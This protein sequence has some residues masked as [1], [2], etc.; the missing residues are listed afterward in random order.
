[1]DPDDLTNQWDF[2]L[3]RNF[4][5]AFESPSPSPQN[6]EV[7][8]SLPSTPFDPRSSVPTSLGDF[9]R[10]FRYLDLPIDTPR[11]PRHNP[12]ESSS[13]STPSDRHSTGPSSAPEDVKQFNDFIEIV[14]EVR[15]KDDLAGT[16][17]AEIRQRSA[18]GSS[19]NLNTVVIASLLEHDSKLLD[20]TTL[21]A[22]R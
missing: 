10:L 22:T 9:N 18:H 12:F 11:N 8:N 15:R 21:P 4:L 19:A 1:M 14:K 16:D 7:P 17:L 5:K 20:D 2:R 13:S 3:A 6:A